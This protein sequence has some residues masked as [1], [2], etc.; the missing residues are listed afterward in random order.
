MPITEKQYKEVLKEIR[1]YIPR[2][3]I[4]RDEYDIL[5]MLEKGTDAAFCEEDQTIIT[6]DPRY[7]RSKRMFR[8][9]MFH[10]L[11]HWAARK[12]RAGSVRKF[13]RK[14]FPKIVKKK[15]KII[16]SSSLNFALG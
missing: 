11:A 15:P 4:K 5:D 10:E 6:R 9:I 16:I 1:K 12:G 13:N 14:S 7:Y 2:V 3:K 8:H